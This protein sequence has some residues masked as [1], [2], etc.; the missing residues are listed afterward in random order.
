MDRPAL[1]TEYAFERML[2][3]SES[4]ALPIVLNLSGSLSGRDAS[5]AYSLS[6]TTT[7]APPVTWLSTVRHSGVRNTVLVAKQQRLKPRDVGKSRRA[8]GKIPE[9]VPCTK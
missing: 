5:G 7:R 2:R 1:E 3:V 6:V 8:G 9:G 4:A